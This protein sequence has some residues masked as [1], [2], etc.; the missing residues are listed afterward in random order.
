MSDVATVTDPASA[1]EAD[2]EAATTPMEPTAT[3]PE[4][5]TTESEPK[6]AKAATKSRAKANGSKR[7]TSKE[8]KVAAATKTRKT[9]SKKATPKKAAAKK[10]ST[11]SEG[12]GRAEGSAKGGRKPPPDDVRERGSLEMDVKGVTDD[13]EAG[14]IDMEGKPLTPH[15][16]ANLI[17]ERDGL[18]RRPSPGAITEVF[19]RWDEYGF[20][21]FDE[22]PTAFRRYSAKG[23]KE[24]L[25]SLKEKG[26][27]KRKE[28][29]TKKREAA[30]AGK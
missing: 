20:A 21:L 13:F 6:P 10:K 14:N 3:E 7:S 29:R 26:I 25:E 15:R 22:N 11:R 24:G 2:N 30:K 19:K 27:A 5:P 17:V 1:E 9:A 4:T 16:I 12:V 23:N 8:K 18:D 28:E